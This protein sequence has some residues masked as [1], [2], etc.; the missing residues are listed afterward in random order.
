MPDA[1]PWIRCLLP[2]LLGLGAASV[3]HAGL[4]SA[5]A[6]PSVSVSSDNQVPPG[7]YGA[8][9]TLNTTAAGSATIARFKTIGVD[10]IYG[11]S[12]DATYN[13]SVK[14]GAIKL[15]Q[16]GTASAAADTVNNPDLFNVAGSWIVSA[17]E[18]TDEMTVTAP[19]GAAPGSVV[20]IAATVRLTA[21]GSLRTGT[22]ADT[23]NK[24]GFSYL[25]PG[26]NRQT[27]NWTDLTSTSGGPGP[28]S[29][30]EQQ[31]TLNLAPRTYNIGSRVSAETNAAARIN[32]PNPVWKASSFSSIDAGNSA[33]MYFEVLTP[34][35]GYSLASGAV[36]AVPEPATVL[37]WMAGLAV[38]LARYRRLPR[39]PQ[40]Q[41][42]A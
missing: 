16:L 26:Q 12:A 42:Q 30:F 4:V 23:Y 36:L 7:T 25:L 8:T 35:A 40:G 17:L 34:G 6:R 1:R 29:S 9:D 31:V 18:W 15:F 14:V 33:Y 5:Y 21:S 11:T 20:Q 41:G 28:G 27:V 19:P 39:C 22:T 2:A 32:D 37:L 13:L 3:S 24:L 10:N 38:G